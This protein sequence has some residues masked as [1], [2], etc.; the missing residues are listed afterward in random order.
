MVGRMLEGSESV[1]RV[2]C[3]DLDEGEVR[4]VDRV[5]SAG[6][7]VAEADADVDVGARGESSDE[8]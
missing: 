5:T 3:V 6:S 8:S 1:E 2:W 4:A 7:A